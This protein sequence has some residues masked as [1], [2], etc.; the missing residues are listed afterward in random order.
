MPDISLF[1]LAGINTVSEDAALQRGGDASSL[2]V[3]DAL[4]FNITPAGRAQ[5]RPGVR[6]TT[7][8]LYRDL[9][10]SPLHGDVFGRLGSQWV[11]IDPTSWTHDVLA[12]VGEGALCH[13]IL[14]SHVSVA[15][16]AGIFVFDGRKA[17]RLTLDTPA[18]P[19]VVSGPGALSA[20]RYGVAV[21]WLRG[22]QESAT[23]AASFVDVPD[24]S[25][26]E[27]T[28]PLCMDIS[29]TGARL[30]L[31]RHNGGE[32]LLAG[33]FPV[34]ATGVAF[35]TLP[36]RGR[37][38]QFSHLS[39]MPTGA[40]LRHWRGRLLTARA[41]VLRW[42]EAMAYHL[43]DERSGFV[44]MPQRIT[45]VLPVE[46][47]VWVGQR[48]HVA[49]LSGDRPEALAVMR[50]QGKP[51]V[52]GSGLL[53][54]AEFVGGDLSAG[55]GPSAMWLAENGYVVGTPSGALVE[56]HPRIL[57][58]ISGQGGSSVVMDNRIT[59]AVF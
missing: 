34:G 15:G 57:S 45:F 42:S 21:A 43:H 46:G 22:E 35:P 58:G 59:T 52:P 6:Q 23:S 51:P 8:T 55:G 20:G 2:H 47:G 13:E 7:A 1:P 10:Q 16:P 9:W 29:V 32:L 48:D 39:P 27:V 12:T 56:I 18:P 5:L 36:D 38:A 53:V 41:N 49:F 26:V 25:G 54:G 37:P 17:Q 19:L 24:G 3:R 40:F 50:R 4:N 30:Y 28:L 44:Q 31:T 33:D 11:R 14:N